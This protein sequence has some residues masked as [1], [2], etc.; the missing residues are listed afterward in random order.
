MSRDGRD[1]ALRRLYLRLTFNWSAA[2]LLAIVA[3]LGLAV[4]THARLEALDLEAELGYH[5]TLV[6]G[7]GWFDD[8][9]SLRDDWLRREPALLDGPFDVW[10]VEPGSPAKIHLAPENPRIEIVDLVPLA[11][12]VV[13]EEVDEVVEGR[14]PSGLPYRVVAA[15]MYDEAEVKKAAI[16][17]AGDARPWRASHGG[18]VRAALLGAATLAALGVLLGAWLSR[19]ALRPVLAS[20]EQQ[21]RFLAAAA[22]ELRTPV[23]SLRAVCDSALE[24][25][26]PAETALR[27][28]DGL[29]RRASTLVDHLLVLARL[30]SP[31][32]PIDRQR[33]R[34]DLLVETCLPEDGSVALETVE[35]T[36]EGEPAL[37]ETAVRNLVANARAHGGAKSA[38]SV[39]V[40]VGANRVTVE[41]NGPGFRPEELER[42]TEPFVARPESAGTG[43]GLAIVRLI[44]ERHGGRLILQNRDQGG[45]RV[46]LTIGTSRFS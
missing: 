39:R 16:L 31:A 5:A 26:E 45:A 36:V 21:E 38:G 24:G 14:D 30:D 1:R 17:V 19:R 7:L 37:L 44:A 13:K 33:L 12:R 29:T 4:V 46:T 20:F 6:Y 41:D 43:L 15:V 42:A 2:W 22:H 28:V 34:L 3:L 40:T 9:G 18:F 27:R 35:S 32:V 23:A 10:I 8:D 11:T 25:D